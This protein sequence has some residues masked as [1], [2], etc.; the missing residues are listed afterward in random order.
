MRNM[1]LP[2]VLAGKRIANAAFQDDYLKII[3]MEKPESAAD[4]KHQGKKTT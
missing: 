4:A 3:F 1:I 2:S